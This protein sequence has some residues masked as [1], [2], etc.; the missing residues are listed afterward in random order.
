MEAL[1][2]RDPMD[3]SMRP[4][5]FSVGVYPGKQEGQNCKAIR[6]NEAAAVQRRSRL[7]QLTLQSQYLTTG[8]ASGAV[9][10]VVGGTAAPM[11]CS[12]STMAA[13]G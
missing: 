2:H 8:F 3:A 12:E 9:A 11:T 4:P 5:L 10:S 7:V 1:Q 13:H 6:F